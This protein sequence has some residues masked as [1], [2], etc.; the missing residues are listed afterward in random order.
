LAY[1]IVYKKSIQ[2]DLK[3][4]DKN[5]ASHLLDQIENDLSKHP[6]SFPILK[7]HFAGL[8]KYRVGNY[9]VIYAIMGEEIIILRIGDR[10][11]VYKK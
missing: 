9:R 5:K 2:R 10:K 11:D 3:K 6:E 7:G 4:L 1:R 8:R